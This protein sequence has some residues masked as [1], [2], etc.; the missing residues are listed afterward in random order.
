[1]KEHKM[2]TRKILNF[3]VSLMVISSLFLGSSN[4]VTAMPM[5]PTDETKVPHYF[6]PYP[7]WA[8]S[9]FTLPNAT[10]EIQGDGTGATAVALVDP[11]SQ[12]IASVQVTSPGSGYTS[13][14][15]VINGG[16]GNATATATVNTSGTLTTVN[17][18]VPGGGYTSPL[19]SFSGGGGLG[20]VVSIGNP[21]IA[22]TYATDFATSPGILAP[23]FVIVPAMMPANGIVQEIQY[24]NQATAGGSPNPSEGNLFHTYILHPTGI[25]DEYNVVWDSGEQVVP[26]AVDPIGEIVSIPVNPGIAVTT[27]DVIAFYGQGIPVDV[28]GGA[29]ILSYPAPSAPAQGSNITVSAGDPNYPI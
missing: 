1:M 11:I 10:V 4:H 20:T 13:A 23:V 27:G 16:D 22:R 26:V 17:V 14:N 18:D 9:P 6:G 28:G 5:D 7:N 8:N 3:V 24:F 2:T 29:D 15:V 19:V 25:A 12:G 21:L